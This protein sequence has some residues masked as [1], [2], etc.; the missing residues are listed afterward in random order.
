M[1]QKAGFQKAGFQKAGPRQWTAEP[2]VSRGSL[3]RATVSTESAGN[4]TPF[5]LILK[6]IQGGVWS[7]AGRTPL[8]PTLA[9]LSE[10]YGAGQFELRLQHGQRVLCISKA[11]CISK[12]VD[13][14]AAATPSRNS[15]LD[16][17]T[18]TRGP[19]SENMGASNLN[20]TN[21]GPNKGYVGRESATRESE[22]SWLAAGNGHGRAR[23]ALRGTALG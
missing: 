12:A 7:E 17:A 2:A 20:A 22:A 4:V 18:R 19:G 8:C 6:K 1:F 15:I 3:S 23:T 16:P 14:A 5:V 13:A 10:K 11:D 21:I 9:W